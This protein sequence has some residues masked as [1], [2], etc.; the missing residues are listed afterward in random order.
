MRKEEIIWKKTKP[1]RKF[2]TETV[3]L[4]LDK[5]NNREVEYKCTK[6][7]LVK[8]LNFGVLEFASLMFVP[9]RN[10]WLDETGWI[11]IGHDKVLEWAEINM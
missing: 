2:L 4:F 1:P 11:E 6:H 10:L 9:A 3:H 7:L 5:D 8:F